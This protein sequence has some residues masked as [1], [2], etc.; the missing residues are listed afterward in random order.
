MGKKIDTLL[1]TISTYRMSQL[2]SL[3]Y[4]LHTHYDIDS[5]TDNPKCFVG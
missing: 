4:P 5:M 3:D 2:V 1:L